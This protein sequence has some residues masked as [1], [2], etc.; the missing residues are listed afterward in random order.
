MDDIND[1]YEKT[2]EIT[3]GAAR[4]QAGTSVCTS[5]HSALKKFCAKHRI[6]FGAGIDMAIYQLMIGAG[7]DFSEFKTNE[8]RKEEAKPYLRWQVCNNCTATIRQPL[9]TCEKCG[10]KDLTILG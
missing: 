4:S 6:N 10:S 9:D 3:R 1:I 5:L 7:N 2:L 8:A